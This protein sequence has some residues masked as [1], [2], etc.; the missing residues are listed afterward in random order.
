MK[1]GQRVNLRVEW[2]LNPAATYS[3][4]DHQQPLFDSYENTKISLTLPEGVS[5]VE[6][7]A[8]T[9]Q[10]VVDVLPPSDG[11]SAWTLLLNTPLDASFGKDGLIVVPLHIDG[12]GERP[13]GQTLDFS[14]P[15]SMETQFTIMDRMNPTEPKPAKTYVKTIQS[16]EN[17]ETK[18]TSTDD[19]WGIQKKRYKRC[20]KRG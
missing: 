12:N 3:Y 18:I 5:I 13:V 1:A 9:M 16:A 14:T 4:T 6:G 7:I 11:N 10:N 17:L 20:A 8:G 2:V 19:V 15:A